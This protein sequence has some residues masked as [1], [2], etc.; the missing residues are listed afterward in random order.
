MNLPN[1]VKV[2]LRKYN[3]SPAHLD[4]LASEFY[5]K[6]MDHQDA[7]AGFSQD[8]PVYEVEFPQIEEN[9]HAVAFFNALATFIKL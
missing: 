4:S 5:G 6:V 9:D 2:D 1:I 8:D 3:L 7:G